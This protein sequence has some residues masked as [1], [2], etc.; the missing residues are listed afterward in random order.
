MKRVIICLILACFV[1]T[2]NAKSW[3]IIGDAL[4][5]DTM[6]LHQD[7]SNPNLYKYVGKLTNKSFKLFD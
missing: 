6:Q 7:A 4:E 2:S 1:V 5:T 3:S